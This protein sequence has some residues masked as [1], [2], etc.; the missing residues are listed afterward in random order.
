[1]TDTLSPAAQTCLPARR[2]ADLRQAKPDGPHR[3]AA[4]P[5]ASFASWSGADVDPPPA[6]LR[7]L[8]Q[9]GCIRLD[10]GPAPFGAIHITARGRAAVRPLPTFRT[11]TTNDAHRNAL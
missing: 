4:P 11:E 2:A 3:P 9:V 6:T 8:E 10:P 1:M 7:A 5:A